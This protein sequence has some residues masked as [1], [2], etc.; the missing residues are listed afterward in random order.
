[1]TASIVVLA[2][3]YARV[4]TG[5]A[6]AKGRDLIL[7]S[8]LAILCLSLCFAF[9]FGARSKARR[10][11]KDFAAALGESE[12]RYRVLFESCLSGILIT[13]PDGRILEANPAA[14]AILGR[15]EAEICGSGRDIVVDPADPRLGPALEERQRTGRFQGELNY[16][17]ADGSSFPA[18]LVSSIVLDEN[19]KRHCS[20]IFQ[21]ISKRK[22]AEAE[23]LDSEE[24]L[25]EV[26]EH[27]IDASYKRNL[28]T[29]GYDYLSP[30][31]TRL[32]GYDTQDFAG[33]T[34]PEVLELINPEDLPNVNRIMA[35][36][37]SGSGKNEFVVEYRLRHRD[38]EYRWFQDRCAMQRDEEGRPLSL[39]GS[40]SDISASKATEGSLLE[41]E[42]KR[43]RLFETMAQGVIYFNLEGRILSAN[44]AAT[45]ILGLSQEQ[46]L[47][48]GCDSPEWKVVRENGEA[49]PTDERPIALTARSGKPIEGFVLGLRLPSTGLR[50]WLSISTVPLFNP[51]EQKPFQ[52]YATFEDITVRKSSEEAILALA[53]R[54]QTLLSELQ[55]RAK[56]SFNMIYGM[57]SI[58]AVPGAS[59]ETR[60]AL[61]SLGARI[62]CV[63][64]LYTLLYSSNSATEAQLDE[65]CARIA[66]P[67]VQ[68]SRNIELEC[69]FDPIRVPA[70]KAAPIGLILTELVTNAVKY[71]FPGSRSGRLRVS[72][73]RRPHEV[74]LEVADDGVGLAAAAGPAAASGMGLKLIQGLSAQIEGSFSMEAGSP[75]TRCRLLF[76]LPELGSEG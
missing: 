20:I 52:I 48:K 39:I 17:R 54:N 47:G 11:A 10:A 65:Y 15:T 70:K 71:A 44:P 75:G 16:F 7:F 60:Q 63:S 67:L 26:L 41:S 13:E 62:A 8:G 58:A 45:R 3:H 30:V 19:G 38:G 9:I 27:S 6:V 55:H 12:L 46:L 18:E 53:E 42:Q 49:L 37:G 31:F 23:R 57:I 76:P 1:M 51:W 14:C 2:I 28:V 74:L 34:L 25:R 43:R 56:N 24:R 69:D 68:L 66:A 59:P 22:K 21:D 40:V 73:K 4:L 50:R 36:A 5:T 29:G 32:S 64:E 61:E 35:A 72:L 33:K